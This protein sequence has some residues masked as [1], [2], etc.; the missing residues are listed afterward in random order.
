MNHQDKNKS[1]I[2]TRHNR[3]D[4]PELVEQSEALA[5]RPLSRVNTCHRGPL[6]PLIYPCLVTGP[7]NRR[8]RQFSTLVFQSRAQLMLEKKPFLCH[9]GI[10]F[11]NN[12]W[13]LATL[14]CPTNSIQFHNKPLHHFVS[15]SVTPRH[16]S[17]SRQWL[18]NMSNQLRL[19]L[20][21]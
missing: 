6:P 11:L 5:P 19:P 10:T 3:N 4:F 18:V 17:G 20:W 9:A 8:P 21:F 15:T 12:S 16:L 1:Y 13:R 7:S 2:L 14:A